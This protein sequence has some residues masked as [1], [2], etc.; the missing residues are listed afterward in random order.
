MNRKATT[1][2]EYVIQASAIAHTMQHWHIFR[3]WNERLFLEMY[4]AYKDGRTEKNPA[5]F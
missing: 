5:D 4:Q 2:I 1:V 3:K